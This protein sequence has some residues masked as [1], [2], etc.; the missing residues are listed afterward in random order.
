RPDQ[1]SAHD[2]TKVFEGAAGEVTAVDSVDVTVG[3]GE[4]V[5]VVGESGSGKS[6]LARL[7]LR[8]IEPT[9]GEVTFSDIDLLEANWRTMQAV[10]RDVQMIFQNPYASLMPHRTISE[11]VS[12][13]LR[14]HR[15]GTKRERRR[16][17][18]DLLE[19]VGIPRS[20]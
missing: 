6:T 18:L 15:V 7:L 17:A 11:N 8:L 5:G 16:T 2:L 1:V 12:E 20:P 10:R 14:L 3:T 9:S 19:Q 4:A 13:P